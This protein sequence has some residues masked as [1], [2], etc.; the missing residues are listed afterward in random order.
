M[1][2][3]RYVI[4]AIAASS[5]ILPGALL[6]A[7][8]CDGGP[9]ARAIEAQRQVFNQAIERADLEAIATLLA[10]DVV[11]ITGTDSNRFSGRQAQLDLWRDDFQS[12]DRLVY[13]RTPE[14]IQLSAGFPIAHELGRWRGQRAD[15]GDGIVG[16]V[17]SAKWRQEGESWKVEAEVFVTDHCDGSMCS[18]VES[19]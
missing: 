2:L 12:K 11:L 1:R 15:G 3:N 17:Y 10:E 13:R 5:I 4:G 6:A 19:E 9:R 8:N 18:G 14:C 16:G 7:G